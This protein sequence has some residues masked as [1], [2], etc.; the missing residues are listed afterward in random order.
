MSQAILQSLKQQL[1]F[2]GISFISPPESIHPIYTFIHFLLFLHWFT[3]SLFMYQAFVACL[4]GPG[5]EKDT[6]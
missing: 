6:L 2:W 4:Y 5:G 1:I 3:H